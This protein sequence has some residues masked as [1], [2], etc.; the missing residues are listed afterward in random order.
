MNAEDFLTSLYESS[1][2]SNMK[3][4]ALSRV[5][6][7]I[8]YLEEHRNEIADE[9]V[10]NVNQMESLKLEQK[11]EFTYKNFRK[12]LNYYSKEIVQKSLEELE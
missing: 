6:Q 7:L 1:W 11:E 4:E 3:Y 8:T 2:K 5:D 10:D 9:M 12:W